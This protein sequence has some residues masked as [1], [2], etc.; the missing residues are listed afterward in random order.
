MY[1]WSGI[2]DKYMNKKN[3][4]KDIL[5]KSKKTLGELSI[6]SNNK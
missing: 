5:S 6:T 2:D 4:I 3:G 1:I